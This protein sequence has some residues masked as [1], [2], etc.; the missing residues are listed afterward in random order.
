MTFRIQQT[1]DIK[2]TIRKCLELPT[3]DY[4]FHMVLKRGSIISKP[5]SPLY[6]HV[7][8]LATDSEG[9]SHVFR[10]SVMD[11]SI[12][13]TT[14]PQFVDTGLLGSYRLSATTGLLRLHKIYDGPFTQDSIEAYLLDRCSFEFVRDRY[15]RMFSEEQNK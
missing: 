14:Y 4:V 8:D 3:D 10:M 13:S 12:L 9:L 7:H 11:A 5:K 1:N 15:K 6:V 2:G